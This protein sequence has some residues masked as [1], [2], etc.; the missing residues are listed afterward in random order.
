LLMRIVFPVETASQRDHL[1]GRLRYF[2][3]RL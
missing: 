2:Y 1:A 3:Y